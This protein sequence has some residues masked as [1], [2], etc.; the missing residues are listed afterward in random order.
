MAIKILRNSFFEHCTKLKI[1]QD[2]SEIAHV[3]FFG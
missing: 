1:K 2:L 3:H